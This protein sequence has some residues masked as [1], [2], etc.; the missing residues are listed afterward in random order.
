MAKVLLFGIGGLLLG[1]AAVFGWIGWSSR[2]NVAA[3]LERLDAAAIRH[4]EEGVAG[5]VEGHLSERNPELVHGFVLYYRSVLYG[6]RTESSSSSSS[7]FGGGGGGRRPIWKQVGKELPPLWIETEAGEVR[8]F[9]DY[10]VVFQGRDPTW[11]TPEE[12]EPGKTER[13]EGL[14]RHQTVTVIGQVAE[15]AGGRGLRAET[16]ASGTFAD[17]RAGERGSATFGLVACAVLAAVGLV[18]IVIGVGLR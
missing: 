11:I 4:G 18:L 12:P 7:P 13:Y 15:D 16:L 6:Y 14:T 1:M 8:I 10:A 17:Y 9:G 5:Y 3:E 2:R